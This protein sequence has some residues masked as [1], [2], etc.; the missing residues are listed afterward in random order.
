MEIIQDV[1][2]M[3]GMCILEENNYHYGQRV[4]MSVPMI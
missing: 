1:L 2:M 4:D 3:Q